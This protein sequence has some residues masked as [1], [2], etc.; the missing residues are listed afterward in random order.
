MRLIYSICHEELH[1]SVV[2]EVKKCEEEADSWHCVSFKAAR[3]KQSKDDRPVDQD[4]DN[5]VL[6]RA[7]NR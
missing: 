1:L 3:D 6:I 4:F 5:S 2:E 7:K